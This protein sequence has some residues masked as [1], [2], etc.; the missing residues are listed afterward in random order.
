MSQLSRKRIRSQVV[1]SKFDNLADI[2][3]N[4]GFKA[5]NGC[6]SQFEFGLSYAKDDFI[7]DFSNVIDMTLQIK[8]SAGGAVPAETADALVSETITEFGTIVP[9]DWAS[10]VSPAHATF[11]LTGAQLKLGV[12][13]YW[14]V[15]VASIAGEADPI[16]LGVGVLDLVGDGY[17]NGAGEA[18]DPAASYLNADQS[19]ARYLPKNLV[20]ANVTNGAGF[21]DVDIS[22]LGLESAPTSVLA[23]VQPPADDSDALFIKHA[24]VIDENTVRVR[25]GSDAGAGYKISILV[26]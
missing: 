23:T 26:S 25:F 7:T 12:G 13:K 17:E 1:T 19:D 5:W 2:F 24:R 22:S 16:T 3:A 11:P 9:A 20:T 14:V 21:V 18:P 6:A 15:L 4:G 10:G 8:A